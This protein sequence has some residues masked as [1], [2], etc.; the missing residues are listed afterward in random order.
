VEAV[1]GD[2]PAVAEAVV[3]AREDEGGHE[4][5][6]VAYIVP[7]GGGAPG[8]GEL[9]AH[10]GRRLPDYMVPSAFMTLQAFPLT[11]NGKVDRRALPAPEEGRLGAEAAYVAPRTDVEATLAAIW[12]QLLHVEQV[13]M[14]DNFF[15]LGGDSM[16]AIR[17]IARAN[18]AGLQL[19]PAQLFEHQTVAGLAAAND[20]LEEPADEGAV[21][22]SVADGSARASSE[23]GK[24]TPSDFPLAGVDQATLDRLLG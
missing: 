17:V 2:H 9:R 11:P 10:L 4:Q 3:V 14:E 20:G 24:L 12:A 7:I 5:R 13:G 19:S 15:E 8:L 16:V 22:G 23:T 6:L 1:L 18:Q 21:E